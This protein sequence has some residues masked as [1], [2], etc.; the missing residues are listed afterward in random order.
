MVPE[1]HG[2]ASPSF[3]GRLAVSS[4]NQGI[5]DRRA[6][7]FPSRRMPARPSLLFFV[8]MASSNTLSFRRLSCEIDLQLFPAQSSVFLSV[9][10]FKVCP[11]RSPQL[12]RLQHIL[13]LCE[14]TN[15]KIASFSK[16]SMHKA[17]AITG[18]RLQYPAKGLSGIMRQTQANWG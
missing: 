11:T 18:F 4:P 14:F 16:L 9:L 15:S 7:A 1:H 17:C 10:F 6:S 3:F 5:G 8:L 13:A 12:S 2:G